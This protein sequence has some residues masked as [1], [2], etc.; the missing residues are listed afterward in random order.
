MQ[1]NPT[2]L[3]RSI[4]FISV[5]FFT[6]GGC[7]T[8]YLA[9]NRALSDTPTQTGSSQFTCNKTISQFFEKQG[10]KN[11]VE[12]KSTPLNNKNDKIN[13][14]SGEIILTNDANILKICNSNKQYLLTFP[15]EISHELEATFPNSENQL[16][17]EIFGT[18]TQNQHG[19]KPGEITISHMELLSKEI[20]GCERKRR[21]NLAFGTEPFWTTQLK[22]SIL[23][24]RQFGYSDENFA[25]T[26][27]RYDGD[28]IRLNGN[29]IELKL[30]KAVCDDGMSDSLYG[31]KSELKIRDRTFKGCASMPIHAQ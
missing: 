14:F 24:F 3:L 18:V 30:T 21:P 12:C 13:H 7:T 20:K 1:I 15:L 17:G 22:N 4:S 11:R 2:A 19:D 28:S 8:H 6:L 16:Y 31:W 23:E 29:N 5:T 10:L 9:N 25:I 26:E 27:Y